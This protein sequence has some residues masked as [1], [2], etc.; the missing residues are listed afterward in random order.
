MIGNPGN[1]KNRTKTKNKKIYL[2]EQDEFKTNKNDKAIRQGLDLS[3]THKTNQIYQ[4]VWCM[5]VLYFVG[6]FSLLFSWLLWSKP[7]RHPS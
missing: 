6:L 2:E 3:T 5:V 1:T 4:I 7:L